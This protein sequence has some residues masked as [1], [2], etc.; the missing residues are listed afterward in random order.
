MRSL[1]NPDGCVLIDSSDLSYL[2]EDEDG[3][4]EID[5]AADYYGQVDYQM[6][7]KD[8]EGES[9]DWL[10][11][12]FETLSYYAEESGFRC[13]L[14]AEGEHYDYLAKLTLL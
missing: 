1:L 10:Y 12:D 6:A 9:F 7:Y 8:V 13:E 5:L 4:L 2:Y 3:N 11:A 14:V